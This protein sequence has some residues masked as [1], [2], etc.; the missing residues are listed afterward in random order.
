MIVLMVV[1]A[2]FFA[3]LL[4]LL[5][6]IGEFKNI[7][8]GLFLLGI[9]SPALILI[10]IRNSIPIGSFVGGWEAISGIELAIE[11]FNMVFLV[12][13]TVVF[14]IIGIYAVSYYSNN[15][16]RNK[17]FLLIL[18][19]HGALMGVFMTKDLFNLFV[20]MELASAS[21]FILVAMSSGKDSKKA[22][23]R[24][25][26]FSL[27]ASYLFL[28][29][30]GI[31]YANTGYLNLELISENVVNSREVD[32]AIG[33]AFVAMILKA[34]IFPLH[35]W[36]PDVYSESDTPICA[37]LA[38]MTRRAPIYA[39]LMFAIHL[40][41]SHLSGLLMLVGFASLFFGTVMALLQNDVWRLLAYTSIGLMGIVMIGVATENI[42]GVSYYIFAHA[43]VTTG[44]FLT[45]GTLSD[46]QRTRNVRKLT[47]QKD[48][49]IFTSIVLLSFALGSLSPSL[50]AYAKSELLTGLSGMEVIVFQAGF[51][52]ALLVMFKMNYLLWQDDGTRPHYRWINLRSGMS[53]APA[54]I[55]IALGLYLY[56]RFV[57]MDLLILATAGLIFFILVSKKVLEYEGVENM[58]VHF[59][60]LGLTNNYYS[61][62]F[63]GFLALVL[64]YAF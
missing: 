11:D 22:A 25:L 29:S 33:M 14:V 30:T 9:I 21:A 45:T 47:Y 8:S 5:S 12:A 27:L 38:A 60:E 52:M 1:I 7:S 61:M 51:V 3:F 56:P 59:R 2:L 44:L 17:F 39:M 15:P 20:L 28:L 23:F 42:M 16:N 18:V 48:V 63:F 46:L 35:F 19:M 10:S 43:M 6:Y 58:S 57:L 37:L 62:V 53:S 4:A 31:I 55:L 49:F 26:V 54:I 40:P 34:G 32:I 13:E 24:Y 41:M 50:N 36:L 64:L